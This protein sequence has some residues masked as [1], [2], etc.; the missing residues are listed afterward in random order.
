MPVKYINCRELRNSKWNKRKKAK[1]ISK[2]SHLER[3]I[4]NRLHEPDN[5]EFLLIK[6][7][8][9][10][11]VAFKS[12]PQSRFCWWYILKTLHN[13]LDLKCYCGSL[14]RGKK[15]TS[16]FMKRFSKNFSALQLPFGN[17]IVHCFA[18]SGSTQQLEQLKP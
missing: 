7:G 16:S 18:Q 9:V 4:L 1:Q 3:F 11:A 17:R 10:C 5:R 14:K 13:A 8:N 6:A 2:P 12:N 15:R